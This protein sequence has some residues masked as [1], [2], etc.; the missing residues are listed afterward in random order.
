MRSSIEEADEVAAVVH[1]VELHAPAVRE[2][3]YQAQ[4]LLI[5]DLACRGEHYDAARTTSLNMALDAVPQVAGEV[6][7]CGRHEDELG[8]GV[9]SGDPVH[10]R[11]PLL[12]GAAQVRVLL[13]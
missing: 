5:G 7:R 1:S 2:L 10:A 8:V 4:P 6:L 13:A 9:R 11:I 3:L 12:R